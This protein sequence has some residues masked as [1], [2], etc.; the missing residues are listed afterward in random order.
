MEKDEQFEKTMSEASSE[1]EGKLEAALAQMRLQQSALMQRIKL[2]VGREENESDQKRER[3]EKEK[4]ET[5]RTQVV[6]AIEE[7]GNTA[8]TIFG[9][10]S[11]SKTSSESTATSSSLLGLS[12]G[13]AAG[14]ASNSSR[15]LSPS[16]RQR[17]H[18]A[19]IPSG[20]RELGAASSDHDAS[21]SAHFTGAAAEQPPSSPIRLSAS[22]L[23]S[24][25]W[26]LLQSE[27]RK[28]VDAGKQAFAQALRIGGD[29]T[30]LGMGG[31]KQS[32][33][34][35]GIPVRSFLR[36]RLR[37]ESPAEHT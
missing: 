29:G 35:V 20:L 15:H 31:W 8:A 18:P 5:E 25:D 26:G 13:F 32:G 33:G 22:R 6:E 9:P 12:T 3:E 11:S 2:L 7:G 21:A 23:S 28:E 1:K 30:T 36:T 10:S 16:R 37:F 4:K 27:G 24:T 19:P 14:R 34:S 17:A